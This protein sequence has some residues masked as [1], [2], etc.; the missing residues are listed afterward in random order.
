MVRIIDVGANPCDGPPPYAGML[1][2]G[3]CDVIGFEPQADALAALRAQAGPREYYLPNAIADGKTRTLRVTAASGMTSLLE[4][5]PSRLAAFPGFTEW[6]AVRERVGVRTRRL[7]DVVGRAD[8]LKIDA[9]GSE[10]MVLRGAHRVLGRAVVVHLEV[11]FVPLY[12]DQPTFGEIDTHMRGIGFVPHLFDAIKRWPLC[13]GGDASQ[14]LEADV[15]YVRDFMR[16]MTDDQRERLALILR[17]VYGEH[18]VH[19][20]HHVDPLRVSC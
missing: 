15:V 18:V 7:D 10:L 4:P 6:G 9:Q 12:H 13:A 8:M 3:L 11:S 20:G 14:V 5:D 2:A 19:Q 16:P 1:A 17:H